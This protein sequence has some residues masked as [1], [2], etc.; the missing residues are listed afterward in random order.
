MQD[1]E[2]LDDLS[3]EDVSMN[4]DDIALPP[5]VDLSDADMEGLVDEI[6]AMEQLVA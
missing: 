6:L 3:Y 5:G 4:F 2:E 1:L